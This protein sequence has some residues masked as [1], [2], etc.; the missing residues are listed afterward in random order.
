MNKKAVTYMEALLETGAINR[1]P[2]TDEEYKTFVSLGESFKNKSKEIFQDNFVKEW[3]NT[4]YD[5][6]YKN[7]KEENLFRIKVSENVRLHN[8]MEKLIKEFECDDSFKDHQVKILFSQTIPNH[9]DCIFSLK[10]KMKDQTLT[11]LAEMAALQEATNVIKP[12]SYNDTFLYHKGNYEKDLMDFLMRADIIDKTN[13]SFQDIEYMVKRQ[14]YQFLAN[15]LNSDLVVLLSRK[16]KSMPRSFK[17]F[18]A[19]DIRGGSKDVKVYI[20]VTD[21]ISI[22]GTTYTM[23]SDRLNEFVSYLTSAMVYGIYQKDPAKLLRN[24]RLIE[25]GTK[26]FAL[27]FT[28]IIDYLRMGGVDNIREKTLYLSSIYYQKC[29]LGGTYSDSIIQDRA[30]KISG[31]TDRE[32]DIIEYQLDTDSFKDINSFV[33]AIAKVLRIDSLK[34]DNFIE[35]WVYLYKSGTQ[36][37]TEYYPA[38]SSLLTNA[39]HGAY[40]NNQKTIE[41]ITNNGKELVAYTRAILQIGSEMV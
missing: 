18:A 21:L 2:L 29:L 4:G 19:K 17:V 8:Q 40:I 36:F 37:A 32:I 41:K 7:R 25:S 13:P 11:D 31:I 39:Y 16:P 34:V 35:K 12:K 20:D 22:N 9:L 6:F 3:T 14:Q 10:P 27:L 1:Q 33:E 38:F 28:H 26:C 30:R 15:I 23:K 24:T 5:G